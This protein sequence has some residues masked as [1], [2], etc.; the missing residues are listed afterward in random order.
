MTRAHVTD[1]VT[2]DCGDAAYYNGIISAVRHME[3]HLHLYIQ[4]VVLPF[5]NSLSKVFYQMSLNAVCLKN[6]KDNVWI[7]V[8]WVNKDSSLESWAREERH[9]LTKSLKDF[10]FFISSCMC[11]QGSY[12]GKLASKD[13]RSRGG[14]RRVGTNVCTQPS[15]NALSRVVS[16]TEK[17]DKWR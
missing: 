4:F 12:V 10:L 15:W 16:V 2:N 17:E 13:A 14:R 9:W 3:L 11:T 7:D 6:V 8:A 1:D 5:I